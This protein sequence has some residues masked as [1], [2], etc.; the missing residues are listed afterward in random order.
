MSRLA[1]REDAAAIA[2]AHIRSWQEAYIGIFSAEFLGSLDV[3]SR[4]ERVG[5]WIE[6]DRLGVLVAERNGDIAGFSLLGHGDDEGW[7]ELLA[8]YALPD[9]WGTGVGHELMVGSMDWFR[10]SGFERAYLWV[11]EQNPR[12]RAFYE[13]HGWTLGKPIRLEEIGGS[14]VTEVRYESD[15]LEVL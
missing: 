15:P 12:A 9:V 7:G 3:D 8:I 11:L 13:S 6:S 4:A 14:A 1:I 5:E 2:T 10:D